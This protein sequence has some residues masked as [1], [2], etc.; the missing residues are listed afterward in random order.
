MILAHFSLPGSGSVSLNPA[1][2]NGTDPNTVFKYP[3][4]EFEGLL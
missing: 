3:E 1:D 2:Q 4:P